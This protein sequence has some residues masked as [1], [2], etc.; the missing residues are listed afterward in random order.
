MDEERIEKEA[1]EVIPGR[2][3]SVPK[4]EILIPVSKLWEWW[5]KREKE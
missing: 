1:P 2:E 5:K 4:V 3:S